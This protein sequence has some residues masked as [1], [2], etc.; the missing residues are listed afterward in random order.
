MTNQKKS[1]KTI[2]F[3]TFF[4]ISKTCLSNEINLLEKKTLKYRVLKILY[5]K[6]FFISDKQEYLIRTPVQHHINKQIGAYIFRFHKHTM[7]LLHIDA[8][9]SHLYDYI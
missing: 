1:I 8:I 3:N 5:F 7:V 9:D 4:L 6:V 2:C